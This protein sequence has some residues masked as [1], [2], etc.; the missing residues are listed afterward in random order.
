MSKT[1]AGLIDDE[2]RVQGAIDELLKAGFDRGDIGLVAPE[3]RRESERVLSGTRKGLAAGAAAGMLLGGV[4]ILLPGIGPALVTGP[5]LAVPALGTLV[6]GLVGAL[7]ASGIA[8]SDAHFYAEGVRRGGT[9]LTVRVDTP[10]QARRAERIL[11]ENGAA[12]AT[13]APHSGSGDRR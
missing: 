9:L 1:L 12:D 3:V 2:D 7:T 13:S 11:R 6:G 10:E 8:E 5:L 4:A